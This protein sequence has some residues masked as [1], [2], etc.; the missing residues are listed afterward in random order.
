MS[1]PDNYEERRCTICGA[2]HPVFGFGPQLSR[3]GVTVWACG[4]HGAELDRRLSSEM[5]N[6][7]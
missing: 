4:V 6:N 1:L 2:E 3:T 7:Q 5:E